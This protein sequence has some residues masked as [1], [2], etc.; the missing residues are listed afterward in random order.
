MRNLTAFKKFK[1]NEVFTPR[2]ADVNTSIY[3]ARP[4]LEKELARSIQGSLHTLIYGNSGTGKSWLYKKVLADLNATY[5][6]ANCANATRMGTLTDEIYRSVVPCG[7]QNLES[8]EEEISAN[9]SMVVANGGLKSKRKYNITTEDPLLTAFQQLRKSGG[10]S[11]ECVLVLDNLETIVNNDV[12]MDEL[13]NI[14]ILCDDSRYSKFRINLLIV[15]VPSCI[16]DYFSKVK[17][18]PT[19]ANRIQEISEVSSFV[20]SQVN[21]FVETGFIHLLG[22]SIPNTVLEVWKGHIYNVTLGIP[23]RLHEY[24]ECL[25]YKLEDNKWT[26]TVEALKDADLN[27][28]SLGLREAYSTVDGLMN[29][30]ETEIGRRN[31]VLYTLGK[32]QVHYFTARQISDRMKKEFP[33]S[34]TGVKLGINTILSAL[35][36]KPN[37]IIK[38]CSKGASFEFTD[39]RYLMT[40]RAMLNKTK[41]EKIVKLGFR[42]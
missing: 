27:W 8:M 30:R 2:R 15:G 38:R 4:N 32:I 1:I 40:L 36:S 37:S 23:Q 26:P 42:L 13:A 33:I 39:P 7:T 35:A 24:C 29:E 5:I 3:I 31:Q 41:D 16:L 34:T 19:V 28:L 18:L 20:G 22:V 14:V 12:L 25:A 11:A 10:A 9:A 21:A 6:V 17:N